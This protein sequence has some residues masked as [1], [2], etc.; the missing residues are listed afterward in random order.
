MNRRWIPLDE[1]MGERN[2]TFAMKCAIVM[3]IATAA[4]IVSLSGCTDLKPLQA[5]ISDLTA[6]VSQL[7]SEIVAMKASAD[8]AASAAQAASLA[9]REAQSTAN[10]ALT[11]A[12]A[13]QSVIDA[14]NEEID[15]T[16]GIEKGQFEEIPLIEQK[17]E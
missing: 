11:A 10:Q 12:Q 6:Q 7:Q 15:R 17:K 3:S 13:A 4:A 9:A 2:G 8:Q 16:L 1:L 5:Q 14:T